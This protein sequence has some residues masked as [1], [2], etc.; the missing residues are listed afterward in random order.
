MHGGKV[1]INDYDTLITYISP[2]L[3]SHI[4]SSAARE[5]GTPYEENLRWI[6]LLGNINFYICL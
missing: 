5:N 1:L 2:S 4:R 3:Q 6:F